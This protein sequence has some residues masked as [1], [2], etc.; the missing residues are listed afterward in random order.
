MDDFP[1]DRV[2]FEMVNE[3]ANWTH[4]S[5]AGDNWTS[6]VREW[7]IQ[8]HGAQPDRQLIVTGV[9]GMR[10]GRPPSVNS[11]TGLILDLQGG[12]LLPPECNTLCM[13]TFHYYEPRQFTAP[14]KN[15]SSTW[16]DDERSVAVM[17]Q[18][19][20]SVVNAT[21]NGVGI[22]LGEFGLATERVDVAQGVRW[23]TAVRRSAVRARLAGYSA[24][25]YYG[26]QNGLVTEAEGSSAFDRLCA[27]DR[28][29][30]AAAALG[31]PAAARPLNETVRCESS[32]GAPSPQN[33]ST[34]SASRTC[35]ADGDVRPLWADALVAPPPSAAPM[36]RLVTAAKYIDVIGA[37]F[38]LGWAIYCMHL[39]WC[40]CARRA[41]R[42][43]LVATRQ[44][45]QFD[46]NAPPPTATPPLQDGLAMPP[47][48]QRGADPLPDVE[49]TKGVAMP[50]PRAIFSRWGARH[51]RV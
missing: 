51:V 47:V 8:V 31:L 13:V 28:S 21:P 39:R 27:W 46:T 20:G 15:V 33:V 5:V 18:D 17:A 11:L 16:V 22:Y 49:D 40:G 44:T 26:T 2:A 10:G 42:D 9:Q 41:S 12:R 23:L 36:A 7:V 43:Q 30:F 24:W 45:I 50:Q 48:L 29:A 19:F 4:A 38:L 3:P 35:P 14:S 37:A 32:R 25:A 34:P 1:V 6:L